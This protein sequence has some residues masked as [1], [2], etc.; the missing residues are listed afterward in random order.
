MIGLGGLSGCSVSR[1]VRSSASCSAA[2]VGS[3]LAR[4][5]GRFTRPGQR[6]RNDRQ[7]HQKV[8]LVQGADQ[9]PLGEFEAERHR[10]AIP[11]RT[12]PGSPR[13]D[14]LGRVRKLEAFPCFGASRLEAPISVRFLLANHTSKEACPECTMSSM[15]HTNGYGIMSHERILDYVSQCGERIRSHTVQHLPRVI[16]LERSHKLLENEDSRAQCA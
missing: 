11:P 6:Q 9:R 4:L 13:G 12:P 15:M 14:S 1:C 3:S 5:G 8:V 10:W 7:E 2:S 16:S